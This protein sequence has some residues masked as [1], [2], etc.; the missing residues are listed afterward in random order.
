MIFIFTL[1]ICIHKSIFTIWNVHCT[2]LIKGQHEKKLYK[3]VHKDN[4][5]IK[6]SKGG[7]RHWIFR[8]WDN[9]GRGLSAREEGLTTS[10]GD[11]GSAGSGIRIFLQGSGS[12]DPGSGSAY[13]YR[14]SDPGSAIR[15]KNSAD[16]QHWSILHLS[17]CFL[18]ITTESTSCYNYL[19][20]IKMWF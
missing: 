13:F 5:T 18:E 9:S 14:V 8:R 11:P 20:I 1:I 3:Q 17:K 10:F 4:L 2:L 6:L 15:A 7:F 12:A 16:L 19:F